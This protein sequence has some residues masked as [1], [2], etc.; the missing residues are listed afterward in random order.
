MKKIK[1]VSEKFTKSMKKIISLTKD[2]KIIEILDLMVEEFGEIND[3]DSDYIHAI[4][5]D[6]ESDLQILE[7]E[8]KGKCDMEVVSYILREIKNSLVKRY[9][10]VA[11]I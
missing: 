3:E 6:I 5:A 8:V 2:V 1:N 11:T 10:L 4:N 7:K 9:N